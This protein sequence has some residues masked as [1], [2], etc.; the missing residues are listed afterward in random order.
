VK[1][2]RAADVVAIILSIG[3]VTIGILIGLALVV[4]VVRGHNPTPTLG[5]NTTQVL[6]AVMGG[7]VGILGSYLGYSAFL[8]SHPPPPPPPPPPASERVTE[9]HAWPRP[10][11]HSE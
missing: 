5:E 3:L 4:N 9:E 11:A 10:P 6:I 1:S 7:L 8:A 2:Y